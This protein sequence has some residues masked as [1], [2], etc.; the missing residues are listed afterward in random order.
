M[1]GGAR[2]G[3][4]GTRGCRPY[5]LLVLS[6]GDPELPSGCDPGP[7]DP[8]DEVADLY[9]SGEDAS[10]FTNGGA[11]GVHVRTYVVGLA[12]ASA[13]LDQ[14]AA[15]GGTHQAFNAY[16]EA[17]LSEILYTII[18]ESILV[19]SCT[20][21]FGQSC[22]PVPDGEGNT[23]DLCVA[24]VCDPAHEDALP[25]A[26]NRFWCDEGHEPP[27][28]CDGAI[29]PWTA[30]DFLLTG[31][32]A[33]GMGAELFFDHLFIF[34]GVDKETYAGGPDPSN[35]APKR[36]VFD[37]TLADDLILDDLQA[38]GS[39]FERDRSYYGMVRLNGYVYAVGGND[40]TVAVT[41]I[42]RCLQ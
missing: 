42:E 30:Q 23:R 3:T 16:S 8:V 35:S 5:I 2:L 33:H 4:R 37:D 15:A 26:E 19:E 12:H 38:S 41:S 32:S 22:Q 36:L 1:V 39:Q 24:D 29:D 6:D 18:D 21:P 34:S 9:D 11:G 27:C 13:T 14:M 17:E 20:C 31:K 7:V 40:G 25:C 28:K 10:V